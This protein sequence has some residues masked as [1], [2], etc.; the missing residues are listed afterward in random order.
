MKS[1]IL[2]RVKHDFVGNVLPSFL[3]GFLAEVSKCYEPIHC[4]I[5]MNFLS[6]FLTYTVCPDAVGD[7]NNPPSK[8]VRKSD[9]GLQF[10]SSKSSRWFKLY[11]DFDP[12]S[13]VF[14]PLKEHVEL[15]LR[16][17]TTLKYLMFIFDLKSSK[18]VTKFVEQNSPV[19]YVGQVKQN[20]RF[21]AN[22]WKNGILEDFIS[23]CG[24]SHH[25]IDECE[26]TID[27]NN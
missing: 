16:V 26:I 18:D 8:V 27:P 12:Q 5:F 4:G 23:T 25:N 24:C 11:R 19:S 13:C 20:I 17:I 14:A 6:S 21:F 7:E 9:D 15:M 22:R 1:P 3:V 2:K 10:V